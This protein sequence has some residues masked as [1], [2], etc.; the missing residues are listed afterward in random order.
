MLAHVQ[1]HLTGAQAIEDA[2]TLGWQVGGK[3]IRGAGALLANAA[4]AA[5]DSH[6][7]ETQ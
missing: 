3:G 2:G 1:H 4:N 5:P 6:R 7:L